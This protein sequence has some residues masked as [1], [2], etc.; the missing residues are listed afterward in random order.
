MND[1]SEQPIQRVQIVSLEIPI[2]DLV[3]VLVKLA[4]AAIPAAI[5]VAILVAIALGILRAI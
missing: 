3:I 2:G 1:K 4:I 5:V